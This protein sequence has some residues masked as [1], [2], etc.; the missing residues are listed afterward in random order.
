M[1]P[2]TDPLGSRRLGLF[3]MAPNSALSPG[4]GAELRNSQCRRA[5]Q[6]LRTRNA[7]SKSEQIVLFLGEFPQ[8]LFQTGTACQQLNDFLIHDVPPLNS[9]NHPAHIIADAD[10]S[11]TLSCENRFKASPPRREGELAFRN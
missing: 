6:S 2:T 11:G 4:F 5:S 8:R 1:L 7:K 10:R 9:T 3:M